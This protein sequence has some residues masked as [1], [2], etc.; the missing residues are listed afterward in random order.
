MA[1]GPNMFEQ[2]WGRMDELVVKFKE[3]NPPW[4]L[5]ADEKL[6]LQGEMRGVAFAIQRFSFPFYQ[7]KDDVSR[8]ALDRYKAKL[9]GEEIQTVGVNHYNPLPPSARVTQRTAHSLPPDQIK[10]L[11][12]AYKGGFP[13]EDLAE[14]YGMTPAAVRSIL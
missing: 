6:E 4:G 3:G 9:A 2:L 10:A 13:I 11:Q 8:H 14:L 12:N 7:E 1:R 5:T